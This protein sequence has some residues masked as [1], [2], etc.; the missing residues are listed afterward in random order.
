MTWPAVRFIDY[1]LRAVYVLVGVQSTL[2]V[3]IVTNTERNN[4]AFIRLPSYAD[5]DTFVMIKIN[6]D[7]G[8]DISVYS[9]T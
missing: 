7:V 9:E 8:L 6:C 5:G 3:F 1:L 4:S 2:Y